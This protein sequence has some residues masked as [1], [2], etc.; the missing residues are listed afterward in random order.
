MQSDLW[1]RLVKTRWPSFKFEKRRVSTSTV[2][3]LRMNQDS[4]V[5]AN[6]T[7]M[8]KQE[9]TTPPSFFVLSLKVWVNLTGLKDGDHQQPHHE[10]PILPPCLPSP[11]RGRRPRL[12][13]LLV[14]LSGAM[15]G[16]RREPDHV[17]FGWPGAFMWTRCSCEPRRTQSL[18][19]DWGC[20]WL[21]GRSQ[22]SGQQLI[23]TAL[24]TSML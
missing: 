7:Q 17:L 20:Y 8:P 5:D 15:W 3:N 12:T 2:C 1:L 16:T 14:W 19:P 9:H 21:Q 24:K 6:A 10:R 11:S 13:A 4:C 18:P 23:L 22:V